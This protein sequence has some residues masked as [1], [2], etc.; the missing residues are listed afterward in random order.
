VVEAGDRYAKW[1]GRCGARALGRKPRCNAG[2]R[3]SRDVR[4]DEGPGTGGEP[5]RGKPTTTLLARQV[6]A[7]LAQHLGQRD[8]ERTADGSEQLARRLLAAALDFGQ[9]AERDPRGNTHVTQRARLAEPVAAENITQHA[10][11][12]HHPST[13]LAVGKRVAQQ[14]QRQLDCT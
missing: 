7:D 1:G 8:L 10:T 11:E 9:I 13:L 2:N 5:D 6:I 3:A 14:C 4:G 12:Q